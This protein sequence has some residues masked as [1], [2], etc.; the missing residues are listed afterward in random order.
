MSPSGRSCRIDVKVGK[1]GVV[2]VEESQGVAVET[3]HVEA[4]SSTAA[5]SLVY[6][7]ER[8]ADGVHLQRPY[9]LI[10]DKKIS[11]IQELLPALEKIAAAGQKELVIIARTSMA[12]P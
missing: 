3:E 2:T 4:C 9:I 5:T 6:G 8:R 10:T 1:D 12:R 11:S 7:H